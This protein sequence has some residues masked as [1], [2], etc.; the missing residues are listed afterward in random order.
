[1]SERET[2]RLALVQL[3]TRVGDLWG[4]VSAALSAV[5]QAMEQGVD[6]VAFPELAITGYPPEDLL[7]HPRFVSENRAALDELC[8]RV[9]PGI[10]VIVGFA[11]PAGGR[12]YNAAA[13]IADRE[14]VAI[15]RKIHLPN[16]GVFDEKRYFV[17]GDRVIVFRTGAG[18]VAV[19]ICED[20]WLPD[21]TCAQAQGGGA[22]LIVNISSSPYHVGKVHERHGLLARR[23]AENNCFIAYVNMVGAQDEL[24]FDGRSM[25]LNPAGE[26]LA[27][28][29]QFE[30]D[31]LIVDLPLEELRAASREP[32]PGTTSCELAPD[33]DVDG[34]EIVS[35]DLG[36]CGAVRE[37]LVEPPRAAF[38][39]REEEVYQALC[40]GLRCYVEGNKFHKVVI[41]ISGG[42]DSALTAA[43]AADTLGPENVIGLIMPSPFTSEESLEDAEQLCENL[44]ICAETIHIEPLMAA[45]E[46]VLAPHFRDL[47]RGVTEEN[48]Q[49]RIRGALLMAFSN[50]Y[51][52]MVLSTGNKSELAMG[53][54]TLYG[55]MVGGFAVL[56]D[57]P[58]TM[59]YA[60]S[61]FINAQAGCELIPRRIL[62]K[63]PS[64]ELKPNQKDSD[65]LPP[66]EVLDPIL[67]AYIVEDLSQQEIEARGF[68]RAVVRRV[69]R[70]VDRN[71]YKRRQAPPGIKITAR[72]FGKDR[73]MPI[74]NAYEERRGVEI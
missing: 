12:L 71:E 17:P 29:G 13:V 1:M 31:L 52:C 25:V 55:D 68:D 42:I 24:V 59:V 61:E 60:I 19:S 56:K 32:D 58:K 41:G 46:A 10:H 34:L 27:C 57:V 15:Q 7:L 23:A 74:T 21:V 37:A 64:A 2:L 28:C 40:L 53:Y 69:I 49:A 30:E 62:T 11:E 5:R 44:G 6:L 22:G 20:I 38:L 73:R 18:R 50:K 35:M 14:L 4:N 16:Y 48:L 9:P 51:G 63:P 47:P 36:L 45:F 70:T 33:P 54:C 43:I 67:H 3:R 8:R 65:V 39:S 66:Y 26:L 72:A